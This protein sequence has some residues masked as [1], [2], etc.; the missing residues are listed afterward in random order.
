MRK[1]QEITTVSHNYN[2]VPKGNA[3]CRFNSAGFM[4]IALNHDNAAALLGLNT[5][6]RYPAIRI[7]F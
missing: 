4:E 1:V 3:L 7:F 6:T 5:G 2:D